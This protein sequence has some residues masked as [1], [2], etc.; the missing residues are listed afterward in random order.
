V[1]TK[2]WFHTGI[3]L[4]REHI[5]RQFDGEYYR[6]PGLNDQE[7]RAL[8]LPDTILPLGLLLEEEREACRA[9]KGMM[10]RQ[11]V[12]ADDAPPGSSEAMIQPYI[13]LEQDFTVRTLQPRAG[14]RHAVFF[15][16]PCEVIT[17]HY[18]RSPADPRIG[19]A[20][21]LEVDD[22]GNVLKEVAVGYGRRE[23]DPAL[24][25][26]ADR[27]K[28]TKTLNTYTENRITNAIDMAD[29]YR[30]PLP[31]ET[32]SQYLHQRWRLVM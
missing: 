27:D 1:H 23:S 3:Y 20:M 15:T 32:R 6:E 22:F 4:D 2:T 7:F 31:A 21:T 16:H 24:P 9:L 26:Q 11:E 18:E 28:Q 10:L 5:S 13:V 12:C 25:L 8:P 14:N 19:H 17:Y 29:D 30:T